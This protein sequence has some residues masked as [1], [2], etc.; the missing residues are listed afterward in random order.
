M[1]RDLAQA[2]L[3]TIQTFCGGP[4]LRAAQDT[5]QALATVSQFVSY[6]LILIH[7]RQVQV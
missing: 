6:D 3:R 7:T 2:W 1:S 5:L 4:Q